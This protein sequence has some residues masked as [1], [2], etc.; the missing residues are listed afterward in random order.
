MTAGAVLQQFNGTVGIGLCCIDSIYQRIIIADIVVGFGQLCGIA[1]NR[2]RLR[3]RGKRGAA[4]FIADF[5]AASRQ[6]GY[7]AAVNSSPASRTGTAVFHGV[8]YIGQLAVIAVDAI[9]SGNRRCIGLGDCDGLGIGV[10]FLTAA[11]HN[12]DGAG[13]KII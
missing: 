9:L 4:C 5:I 8:V 6:T 12:R 13:G 11:L 10:Q 2:N 7:L 3:L 1:A